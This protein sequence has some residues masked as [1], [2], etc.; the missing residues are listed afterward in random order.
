MN[1]P[2]T[3][4]TPTE[5]GMYFVNVGDVVDKYHLVVRIFHIVDGDLVDEYGK[6][7]S[8]Y[9]GRYKFSKIDVEELNEQ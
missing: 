8:A 9:N 1:R 2:W 4:D 7:A 5:D 6:P 3:A